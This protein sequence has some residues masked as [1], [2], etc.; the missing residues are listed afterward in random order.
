VSTAKPPLLQPVVAEDK[1]YAK[2][3]WISTAPEA[4][5]ARAMLNDV[6]RD[7]TD[8][9]GN[10]VEQFQSTA[11]DARYFEFYLFA[12]LQRSGYKIDRTY[13]FPDFIVERGG[14][15]A[16]IEATTTNPSTS[17]ALKDAKKIADLTP[18]E[19]LNYTQ[20]ELAI[21]FGGPL[22]ANFRK[23][24]W[25]QPQCAGLPLVFAIATFHDEDALGLTDNALMRYLYGT[26]T[27]GE[28][29]DDGRLKVSSQAVKKHAARGKEIPSHFFG[30]QDT[31]NISAVL[32][33]NSGTHAKFS[34]TGYQH[35]YETDEIEIFRFGKSYTM[36]N[37]AK[38]PTHF[39]YR[40]SEPQVVETWGQGL[41][42]MH[43]PNA[44]NPLPKDFF[45]DAVQCYQ[46]H[47]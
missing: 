2:F 40:L 27:T 41:C 38:D 31:E 18:D 35:G 25:D 45:V 42:V 21:R 14:A 6:Y 30:Q 34:R 28:W 33:T 10:F 26:T 5:C 19:L 46:E 13:A 7:F 8:P 12:Y 39:A 11:F 15:R 44:I 32:F 37:D 22:N 43:D 4:A 47:G 23:R 20:N 29:S 24:Y 1:L 3:K 36:D 16:A 9:D 17:G